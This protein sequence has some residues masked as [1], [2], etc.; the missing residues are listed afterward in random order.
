MEIF[1]TRKELS[2]LTAIPPSLLGMILANSGGAPKGRKVG[3]E[4]V[5]SFTEC[6]AYFKTLRDEWDPVAE[7]AFL[8]ARRKKPVDKTPIVNPASRKPAA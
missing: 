1:V 4:K 2:R 3:G 6:R 5:Y 7:T 8:A